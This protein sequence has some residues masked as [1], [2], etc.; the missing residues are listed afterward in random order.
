MACED[1]DGRPIDGEE[2][3]RAWQAAQ[4]ILKGRRALLV[5]DEAENVFQSGGRLFKLLSAAKKHKG[6]LNRRLEES[7]VPTLWLSNAIEGLDP[8]FT[9]RF[10]MVF[11]LLTPPREQRRAL[12]A[13]AA[14]NLVDNR[15]LEQLAAIDVLTPAVVTRATR[16]VNT[17]AD[18]LPEPQR[19]QAQLQLIGQTLE[20]QG[21]GPLRHLGANRLPDEYDSTL[22]QVDSDVVVLATG[23]A[24]VGSGRLCFYGPPGTGKTAFGQWLA[25]RMEKPIIIKRASDLLS[26]WVGQAERILPAPSAKPNATMRYC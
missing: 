10:D 5:F 16:V 6:W 13:K 4:A 14:G 2:R 9:R 21:H 12:I 20:A 18:S 17:L 22:I 23:L 15:T 3:L 26:K 7:P 25:E 1:E 19:P 24:D 8:A 11:E